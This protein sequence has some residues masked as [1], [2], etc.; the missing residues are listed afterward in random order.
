MKL[1][2]TA[3]VQHD[4]CATNKWAGVGDIVRAGANFEFVQRDVI[5][6]DLAFQTPELQLRYRLVL[7]ANDELETMT[8]EG[9][10][11]QVG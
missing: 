1:A 3:G 2:K 7:R 4:N 10:A 9:K 6:V 5:R 11:R 8:V